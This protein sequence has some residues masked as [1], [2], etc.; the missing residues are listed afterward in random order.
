[1]TFN[2]TKRIHVQISQRA[3]NGLPTLF[4]PFLPFAISTLS[5]DN[6]E[7]FFISAYAIFTTHRFLVLDH[8]LVAQ[9]GTTSNRLFYKMSMP[10]NFPPW[11]IPNNF[12]WPD[13]EYL[14]FMY[15]EHIL[16]YIWDNGPLD[17]WGLYNSD[18]YSIFAK[19]N[20]DWVNNLGTFLQFETAHRLIGGGTCAC[21][22]G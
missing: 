19:A 16:Y 8:H 3:G 12:C 15:S 9:T 7:T 21:L 18:K 11:I 5:V 10:C 20:V 6:W 4:F 1:M 14:V 2:T 17:S 13:L 22:I